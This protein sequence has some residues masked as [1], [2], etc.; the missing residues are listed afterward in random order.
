MTAAF[1]TLHF[2][3]D[4]IAAGEPLP[5]DAAQRLRDAAGELEAERER[6]ASIADAVVRSN[7]V[8]AGVASFLLTNS[9]RTLFVAHEHAEKE[10][11]RIAAAIREATS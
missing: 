11:K 8:T 1:T 4:K 7:A 9:G 2:L 10:A 3:A 5:A 6:C